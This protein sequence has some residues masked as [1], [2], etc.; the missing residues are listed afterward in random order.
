M[1]KKS[2]CDFLSILR[3]STD[4]YKELLDYSINGYISH[5]VVYITTKE[6]KKRQ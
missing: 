2:L 3:M 1:D 4:K 6:L 5:I